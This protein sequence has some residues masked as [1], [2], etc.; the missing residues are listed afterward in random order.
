MRKITCIL[1]LY[2]Y[3]AYVQSPNINLNFFSSTFSLNTKKKFKT[4][5]YDSFKEKNMKW[6]FTYHYF[7]IFSV[8]HKKKRMKK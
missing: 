8:L 4:Y 1:S 6:N 5:T 3:N 7:I 2:I